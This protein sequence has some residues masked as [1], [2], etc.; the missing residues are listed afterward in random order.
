MTSHSTILSSPVGD[1]R[2]VVD[3]RERLRSIEFA[4]RHDMS[5]GATPDAR[6]CARVVRQ[7]REYFAGERTAFDLELALDGTPFQLG[8]WN[9]LRAI[10]YGE[11]CSYQAIAHRIG[12]PKAVRAVGAA[13]GRN[14]I[15]I[16]VPCHRVIGKDGSLT[17]FGGGLGVKQRLLEL[18]R[19]T[20]QRR[21]PIQTT[22]QSGL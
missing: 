11:T 3:D 21:R 4:G 6:R 14:P 8:V 12:N 18:E 19:A 7:L 16:V 20:L 17:G 9:A 15:P 2:I 22:G 10:A 5:D 1:L 13:N